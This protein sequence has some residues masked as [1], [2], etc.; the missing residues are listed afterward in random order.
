MTDRSL[1]SLANPKKVRRDPSSIAD[2]TREDA[3]SSDQQ[4]F[5]ESGIRELKKK[6]GRVEKI[7]PIIR[8]PELPSE[9]SSSSSVSSNV[10]LKG[11]KQKK[12]KKALVSSTSSSSSSSSSSMP[13][14]FAPRPIMQENPIEKEM[15]QAIRKAKLLARIEQLEDRGIK[16]SKN[17]TYK[18]SEQEMVIEVAK[19]E[20]KSQRGARIKQGRAAFITT[21]AGTE[22]LMNMSD[23]RKVLPWMWYM[24]DI[25]KVVVSDI[26]LFDDCL[27]RGVEQVLGPTG[28]MPWYLECLSI[29]I[30]MMVEKSVLNR[31]KNDPK[32]TNEVLKQ[33][34]ELRQNVAREI[35]REEMAQ[36]QQTPAPQPIHS[37]Q[38]QIPVDLRPVP[39][40]I[41]TDEQRKQIMEARLRNLEMQRQQQQQQQ[42]QPE[43]SVVSTPPPQP[44]VFEKQGGPRGATKRVMAPPPPEQGGSDDD[45]IVIE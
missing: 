40:P 42:P 3:E 34:P 21:I 24:Q 36:R 39:P 44:M 12:K 41:A 5:R 23:D 9:S 13:H 45:S 38:H 37:Q 16:A 17:F 28:E 2:A 7:R 19:M 4:K 6:D 8:R 18:S 26:K 22:K 14:P 29:L 32:H 15:E 27:E 33:N 35:V 31:F 43:P 20:V 30:P 10:V 11:A 1:D 25:T